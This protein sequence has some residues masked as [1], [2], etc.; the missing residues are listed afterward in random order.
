MSDLSA[1]IAHLSHSASL[2]VQYSAAKKVKGYLAKESSHLATVLEV[3]SDENV[4]V[5]DRIIRQLQIDPFSAR[6]RY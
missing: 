5:I 1:N 2:I 6:D 3:L 4:N